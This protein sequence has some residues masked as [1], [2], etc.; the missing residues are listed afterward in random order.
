[1]DKIKLIKIINNSA[2]LISLIVILGQIL[3]ISVA[4]TT[5]PLFLFPILISP[6]ILNWYFCFIVGF[7][8]HWLVDLTV[9]GTAFSTSIFWELGTGLLAISIYFIY[10]LKFYDWIKIL[11]IILSNSIF[12]TLFGI[13]DWFITKNYVIWFNQILIGVIFINN[14]S[15]IIF[16]FLSKKI[17]FRLIKSLEKQK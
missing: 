11:L 6:F 3:R 8:G 5:I 15:L 7:L 13:I 1:M 9:F 4:N 16:Y 10:K 14:I 12:F 17:G 2:L